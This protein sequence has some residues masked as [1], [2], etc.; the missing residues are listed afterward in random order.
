MTTT[1]AVANQKGGVAKTTTVVSLGA[2]LA[3]LGQRLARQREAVGVDA[4]RGQAEDGVSG[5][6]GCARDD[7][8]DLHE[9][10]AHADQVDAAG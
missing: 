7:P 4:A 3:E 8:R 1:I 5:P 2:A 6:D 9:A 10:D